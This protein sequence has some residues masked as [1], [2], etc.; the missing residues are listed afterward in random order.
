[1]TVTEG[2]VVNI[3]ILN[4]YKIDSFTGGVWTDQDT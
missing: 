3:K 2:T 1:M 4:G